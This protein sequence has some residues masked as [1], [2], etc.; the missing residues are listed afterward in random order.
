MDF[1]RVLSG[2]ILDTMYMTKTNVFGCFKG[3]GGWSGNIL[4]RKNG[5]W[6]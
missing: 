3:G 1:D 6:N 5:V 2:T 4:Q